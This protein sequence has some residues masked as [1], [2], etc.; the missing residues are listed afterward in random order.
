MK[1][2][3]AIQNAQID[4]TMNNAMIQTG[5][6]LSND[7]QISNLNDVDSKEEDDMIT[8]LSLPVPVINA[9]SDDFHPCQ[10]LADLQ[11]FNEHRGDIR[12]AKIAFVGD[13]SSNVCHSWINAS[14]MMKFS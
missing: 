14:S 8:K 1:R 4:R 11:T 10:L 2:N 5:L 13:G 9:L 7:M 6:S 12:D 3:K